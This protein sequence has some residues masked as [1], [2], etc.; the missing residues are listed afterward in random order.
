[1]MENA[2]VSLNQP[3]SRKVSKNRIELKRQTEKALR[4]AIME[5]RKLKAKKQY[6][7]LIQH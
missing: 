5:R 2:I 7:P 1:M 4:K 6:Q 3:S